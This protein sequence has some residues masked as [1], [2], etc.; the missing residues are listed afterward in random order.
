MVIGRDAMFLASVQY[1][2]VCDRCGKIDEEIFAFD[3]AW[4]NS[5]HTY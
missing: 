1:V 2:A 5:T 3:D 4:V